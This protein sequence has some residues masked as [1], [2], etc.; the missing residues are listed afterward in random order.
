VRDELELDDPRAVKALFDPLRH[1]I[2][3][4]LRAPRSVPELA[5]ELE[6]PANRLYYHL[7]R[8]VECG[9]VHQVDTRP[10]GRHTERI[11]ERVAERITFSGDLD[12]G[13]ER[14]LRGIVDELERGLR[15]VQPGDP[16]SVSY[17]VVSLTP[18]RARE[19]EES[20]RDLIAGF[21]DRSDG[22]GARRFAVLGALAPL[23]PGET[24]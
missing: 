8:L 14:P 12:L 15:V 20:L 23:P 10:A 7:R 5:H 19:L 17:H 16:A 3:G 22:P 9:L 13:G 21:D 2:F 1:R 24:A 4:L 11:Y 6:L 18:A